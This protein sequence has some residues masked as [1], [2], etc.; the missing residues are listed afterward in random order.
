MSIHRKGKNHYHIVLYVRGR[1]KDLIFH[2]TRADAEAFAANKRL[3]MQ[4][5]DPELDLRTV[6]TFSNFCVTQY[7]PHA[8]LHL[9]P[10]TWKKN[11]RYQVATLIEFFGDEKMSEIFPSRMTAFARKRYRAGI[12][13]VSIN[14]ELRILRRILNFAKSRNI[15]VATTEVEFLPEPKRGRVKVWTAEEVSRL[16]QACLQVSPDILPMVVFLANTGCRRGEA[17]A[18]TWDNV[19]VNSGLIEITPSKEWQP[20]DGEPREIP[21][22]DALTPWLVGE[23]ASPK[24]VFPCPSTGRR[25][26]FWPERKFQRAQKA[27]GLRGGAHTLRHTYASHFLQKQPDLFLLARVLGHSDVA[28]TKL[29]SH[30]LPDHL[31]RARNAVIFEP[32]VG[33]AALKARERWGVTGNTPE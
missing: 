22:G 7:S 20:K 14:S 23:R 29:Y 15:P 16:F 10:N 9:N 27:A 32:G 33:P 12:A 11:R 24:W 18:L 8:Q 28:V 13:P 3:K 25:Y 1:R 26:A 6:P 30:L 19:N 31:A 5:E 2:G 21:I 4:A 17:L